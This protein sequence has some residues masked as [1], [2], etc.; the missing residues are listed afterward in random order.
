MLASCTHIT[1]ESEGYIPV[2][3]AKRSHHDKEVKIQG[4]KEFYLWGKIAPDTTVYL[5]EE[6]YDEGVISVSEV[7]VKQYQS[8]SQFL[9]GFLSL[10]FYIPISYEATGKGAKGDE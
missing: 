4:V 2:Y 9:T 6:F 7:Q 8:F 1:Y 10:G 5:D 3:L